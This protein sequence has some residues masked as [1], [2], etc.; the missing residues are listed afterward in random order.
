MQV[1]G[2]KNCDTV[3]KALKWLDENSVAYV[4][5]DYKKSVPE[6]ALKGFIAYFGRDQ[7]INRKGI[8]WKRLDEAQKDAVMDDASALALLLEKPSAIKRPI[9]ADDAGKPLLL[10]F[11]AAQWQEK[12]L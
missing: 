9:V 1:Y 2:I 7:V 3:K 6:K 4:F 10:G 8:T 5:H 12:L 11:D